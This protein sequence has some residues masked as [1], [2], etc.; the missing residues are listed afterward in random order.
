MLRRTKP[1]CF[2]AHRLAYWLYT[3]DDPIG[4][5]VMHSCNN[6]RCCRREHLIKGTHAE[7]M[8]EVFM[9]G[10]TRVP[11][12]GLQGENNHRARFRDAEIPHIIEAY[13]ILKSAYKVARL[14]GVSRS[15]ISSPLRGKSYKYVDRGV[16]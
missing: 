4:F 7:N 1:C 15:A 8:R 16:K 9:N 11:K 3:G 5:D 14:Y 12:K 2:I 6:K 10:R 13:A